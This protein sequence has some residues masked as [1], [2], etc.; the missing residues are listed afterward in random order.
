MREKRTSF[1]IQKEILHVLEDGN[2]RL[3]STLR[4]RCE[5]NYYTIIRNCR[6]LQS[7]GEI[8]IIDRDGHKF[9]CITERGG[10]TLEL[11]RN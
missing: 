11:L 8:E 2:E 9:A 5:T 10:K 3:L 4:E 6:I 1:E 7:R